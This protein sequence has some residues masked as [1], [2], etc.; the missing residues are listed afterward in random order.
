MSVPRARV[1][2]AKRLPTTHR[3]HCLTCGEQWYGQAAAKAGYDHAKRQGAGGVTWHESAEAARAWI[4]AS[5]MRSMR[6]DEPPHT[7]TVELVRA[8]EDRGP[9]G[10]LAQAERDAFM[11][12]GA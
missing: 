4:A 1:V 11:G 5:F 6:T 10:H 3:A 12:R 9:W 7:V 2:P 8:G